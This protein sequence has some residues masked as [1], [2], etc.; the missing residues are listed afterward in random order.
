M[1]CLVSKNFNRTYEYW[2]IQNSLEDRRSSKFHCIYHWKNCHLILC[3]FTCK[4]PWPNVTNELCKAL[5]LCRYYLAFVTT[6]TDTT[7]ANNITYYTLT[8]KPQLALLRDWSGIYTFGGFPA[9]GAFFVAAGNGFALTLCNRAST[10]AGS[11]IN[12]LAIYSAVMH[13]SRSL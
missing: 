3:I 8:S 1:T 4:D 13:N 6:C 2:G 9:S 5:L 11:M 10:S 12:E 7:F